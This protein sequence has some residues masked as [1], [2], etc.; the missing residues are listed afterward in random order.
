MLFLARVSIVPVALVRLVKSVQWDRTGLCK[1]FSFN[2]WFVWNVALISRIRNQN[3][4]K[5]NI[6]NCRHRTCS[7]N[8]ICRHVRFKIEEHGTLW[9][10]RWSIK[11]CPIAGRSMP[12]V[13]TF[14]GESANGEVAG[15][16]LRAKLFDF[17]LRRTERPLIDWSLLPYSRI[18]N[19]L[20][21]NFANGIAAS[22][23][24][25][26]ICIF[27]PSR[28][29]SFWSL[30]FRKHVSRYVRGFR[31]TYLAR[32]KV[33]PRWSNIFIFFVN[34]IPG[35]LVNFYGRFSLLSANA[36]FKGSRTLTNTV[37]FENFRFPST[38]RIPRIRRERN[39]QC[40]WDETGRVNRFLFLK[41]IRKLCKYSHVWYRFYR[42]NLNN[43]INAVYIAI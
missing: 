43:L 19:K 36:D 20:S 41:L 28:H 24:F 23:I 18:D 13:I 4:T 35:H 34:T 30:H 42:A 3:D 26:A 31:I 38:L 25:Y 37:E 12:F 27:R 39:R 5:L 33:A 9:N 29:S 40:G 11:S 22:F 10:I 7:F 15:G 21:G 8:Y 16:G 14:L 17:S 6:W 2:R 32:I 1:K